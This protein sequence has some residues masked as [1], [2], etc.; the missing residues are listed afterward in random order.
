MPNAPLPLSKEMVLVTGL[1]NTRTAVHQGVHKASAVPRGNR[2][3]HSKGRSSLL[4][5]LQLHPL[6]LRKLATVHALT[7]WLFF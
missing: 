6:L 1:V 7:S 5:R 3:P 2:R 4:G